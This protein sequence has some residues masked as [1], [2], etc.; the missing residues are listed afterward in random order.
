M[1][2]EEMQARGQVFH[3]ELVVKIPNANGRRETPRFNTWIGKIPWVGN[4]IT[5]SIL[6]GESWFRGG[7]V[8]ADHGLRNLDTN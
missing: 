3:M 8:H 7:F 4:D 6:P 5:L 2:Q 1:C